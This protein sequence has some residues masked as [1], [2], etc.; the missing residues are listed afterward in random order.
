[1]IDRIVNMNIIERI[2]FLL[3][4]WLLCLIGYAIV[5]VC[6]L[7]FVLIGNVGAWHTVVATDRLLNAALGGRSSETLSSRAHRE[8]LKGIT[9]WCILCKL[10]DKIE[11]DHCKKSEGI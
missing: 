5:I 1:M 10:L 2:L 9:H 3:F 7:F 11:T 6:S 8:S 4:F